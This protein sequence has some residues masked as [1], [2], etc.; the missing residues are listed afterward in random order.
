[1]RLRHKRNLSDLANITSYFIII[2]GVLLAIYNFDMKLYQGYLKARDLATFSSESEF[3]KSHVSEFR[4]KMFTNVS[5]SAIL[6]L[7]SL[8]ASVNLWFKSFRLF[9]EVEAERIEEENQN[10]ENEERV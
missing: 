5:I 7:I 8:F 3:L 2:V 10:E 1:M 9:Q 4:R 6:L